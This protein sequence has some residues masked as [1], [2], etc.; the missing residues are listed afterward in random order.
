MR[1][2]DTSAL[3][4]FPTRTSSLSSGPWDASS[5]RPE[6]GGHREDTESKVV[7]PSESVIEDFGRAMVDVR[8]L[9]SFSLDHLSRCV[10]CY[11]MRD[12]CSIIHKLCKER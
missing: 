10:S 6:E 11:S 2:R 4:E 12:K 3:P 1:L 7:K 5:S 8:S 9:F